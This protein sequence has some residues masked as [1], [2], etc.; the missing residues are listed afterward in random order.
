MHCAF[1]AGSAALGAADIG[2]GAIAN[3]QTDIVQVLACRT[4]VAVA[5]G[6]VDESL[7]AVAGIVLSQRVVSR[8][9]IGRDATIQQPLQELSIA[10]G[11]IGWDCLLVRDVPGLCNRSQDM[12]SQ[13]FIAGLPGRDWQ[14]R[15]ELAC[16]PWRKHEWNQASDGRG[17]LQPRS[18]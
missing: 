8:A 5:I 17:D 9:H 14:L 3:V 15:A 13:S 11:R 18:A 16:P 2:I 6:Q 4:T 7:R 10:V 1:W 12:A